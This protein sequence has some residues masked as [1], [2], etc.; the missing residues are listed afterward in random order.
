VITENTTL[1]EDA[2][3]APQTEEQQLNGRS[4]FL[5]ETV[6]VG[7]S[8][9]TVF[10]TEDEKLLQM[11]GLFPNLAYAL[12]QIDQLRAGVIRHFEQAAQV[13]A[14]IIAEQAR[15]AAAKSELTDKPEAQTSTEK[16]KNKSVSYL[17]C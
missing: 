9:R 14:Q 16:K 11:P 7:V 13:G 12:D 8:V 6:P 3:A 5:I 1:S 2:Q 15:L 17:S 4:I 10:L